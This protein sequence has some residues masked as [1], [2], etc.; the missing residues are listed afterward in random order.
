MLR[1]LVPLGIITIA[2]L[3]WI[4]K[5]ARQYKREQNNIEEKIDH[6]HRFFYTDEFNI[7]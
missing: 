4:I 6:R 3:V 1:I 5:R 7:N 2:V